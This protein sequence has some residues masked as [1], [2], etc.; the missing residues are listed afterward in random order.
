[1]L[2]NVG[3]L[4]ADFNGFNNCSKTLSCTSRSGNRDR[5]E[6]QQSAQYVLVYRDTFHFGQ[7]YLERM[8]ANK[9]PFGNHTLVRDSKFGCKEND[10]RLNS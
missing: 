8:S 2:N 3:Y 4:L 1:M 7:Q 9:G 6:V 10:Q 5:S